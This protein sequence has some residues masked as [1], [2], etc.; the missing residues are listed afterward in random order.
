M[1][2]FFFLLFMFLVLLLIVVSI[3][4]VA[5]IGQLIMGNKDGLKFRSI[6]LQGSF[7]FRC[8][9]QPFDYVFGPAI[10]NK[11][12]NIALVLFNAQELYASVKYHP[13]SNDRVVRKAR[14]EVICLLENP[15]PHTIQLRAGMICHGCQ[16]L[17]S[18]M[19]VRQELVRKL[20]ACPRCQVAFYCDGH[21]LGRHRSEHKAYCDYF[22]ERNL[23]GCRFEGSNYLF[24]GVDALKIKTMV[25]FCLKD[26]V[27]RFAF[28]E[29]HDDATSEEAA[30]GEAESTSSDVAES[31]SDATVDTVGMVSLD[32]VP[33]DAR[34]PVSPLEPLEDEVGFDRS[35][36]SGDAGADDSRALPQ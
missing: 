20:T 22:V 23:D 15:P 24:L 25:D 9:R 26:G 16:K 17:D 29:E 8:E 12:D 31:V 11:S 21:C 33:F 10:Y 14:A 6:V 2:Q 18:R 5:L 3:A 19:F 28:D 27:A 1:I 36:E 30:T 35:L 32:E 13:Q 7:R 34:E 4:I